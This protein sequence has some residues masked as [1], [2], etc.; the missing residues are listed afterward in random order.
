M[1]TLRRRA[2]SSAA[3]TRLI[4]PPPSSRSSRYWP[5][6]A[7]WRRDRR[8]VT[9]G[10]PGDVIPG[11]STVSVRVCEAGQPYEAGHVVQP[12]PAL[13]VG[14]QGDGQFVDPGVPGE[15]AR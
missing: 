3:K 1:T 15:G 14:D 4:P 5:A 13:G 11:K 9:P 7:D 8:S 2:V 10:L 6:M 12:D